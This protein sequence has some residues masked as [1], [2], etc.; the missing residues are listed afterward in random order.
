MSRFVIAD[1]KRVAQVIVGVN[2]QTGK[3]H[4]QECRYY[5]STDKDMKEDKAF[6]AGYICGE[7]CRNM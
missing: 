7:C 4:R 1:G 3:Y 6:A 5:G 2:S